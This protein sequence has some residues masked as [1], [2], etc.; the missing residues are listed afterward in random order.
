MACKVPVVATA[1]PYGPGEIIE[2]GVNGLLVGMNDSEGMIK[3]IKTLFSEDQLKSIL[4]QAYRDFKESYTKDGS[5]K[6]EKILLQVFEEF[7]ADKRIIYEFQLVFAGKSG[8]RKSEI[9]DW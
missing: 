4:N 8:S 2:N 3:A 7:F 6:E 9:W 1:C 5:E